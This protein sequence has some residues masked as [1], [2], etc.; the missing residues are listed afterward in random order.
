MQTHTIYPPI[1][2]RLFAIVFRDTYWELWT[3]A[4][5]RVGDSAAWYGVY[6]ELYLDGTAFTI[7]RR[8]DMT[9]ERMQI[10]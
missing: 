10:R 7:N 4:N 8:C 1:G 3:S 2:T 9:E 5:T 6:T